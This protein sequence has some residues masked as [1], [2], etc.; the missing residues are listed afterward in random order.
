MNKIQFIRSEAPLEVSHVY[1]LRPTA[2]LADTL[3]QICAHLGLV[4]QSL[5]TDFEAKSD[6][7][8]V[9][10]GPTKKVY[11]VG[12][13]TKSTILGTVR[14]FFHRNSPKLG[15]DLGIYL[16]ES[17]SI[18]EL[19]AGVVASQ[20]QVSQHQ[21]KTAVG[22][23]LDA[24]SPL[25]RLSVGSEEDISRGI[26]WG[27]TLSRVLHVVDAPPNFKT[28]VHL[29]EHIRVS[30][31]KYGYKAEV[32]DRDGCE[33]LGLH[34][35]LAVS[36]GSTVHP[37]HFVVLE[38]GEKG[39]G[40]TIGLVGKGVTFDTG[41]I[42]LK[43]GDNMHYM[44]SDMAGAAAVWGAVELAARWKLPVH[45]VAAL[46]LTENGVDGEA[47]KPGDVIGSYAGKTI[48]VIHTDAEGRLILADGIAY[49]N[50]RFRPDYLVDLATLTG[51]C[52]QALGYHAAA[53]LSTHD[54]LA[55]ELLEVGQEVGERLWR[56][57]LWD[58]Y[59]EMMKSDIADIKNL[60]AAPLA[61]AITA[62]KFLEVFTNQHPRWAHLDIAGVAF[63]DTPYAKMKSATGWGVHLLIT[64]IERLARA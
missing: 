12:L 43:P 44:K 30:A 5:V 41:G 56:M 32:F 7:T 2:W 62:A 25:I 16:P 1:F 18:Q 35:L 26:A 33:S 60:S 64:W 28:P 49:L 36:K 51:N 63:G 57:P 48:E 27:E 50:E 61:G 45:I 55:E 40:P 38:Y 24:E 10:Y 20:Y 4:D 19:V 13:G 54:G 15:S 53:L 14:L 42:G 11:L 34:A 6:E 52:I 29:S 23:F 47:M 21:V 3:V 59:G 58:E 37:A 39:Q 9:L 31:G 17:E 22:G 8:I 46:P